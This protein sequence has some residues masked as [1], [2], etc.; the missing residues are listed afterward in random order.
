MEE[1][2]TINDRVVKIICD[3]KC[4]KAWGKSSRMIKNEE[5]LSDLELGINETSKIFSNVKKPNKWCLEECERLEKSKPGTYLCL[6]HLKDWNKR[7][8]TN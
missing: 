4:D 2:V 5:F 3:D 7:Q 8:K 6:L 1:L